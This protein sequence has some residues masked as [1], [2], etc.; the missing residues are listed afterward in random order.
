MTRKAYRTGSYLP[1]LPDLSSRNHL[2]GP[3][4]EDL[5]ASRGHRRKG[6]MALLWHRMQTRKEQGKGGLGRGRGSERGTA[7]RPPHPRVFIMNKVNLNS[8]P[9][10][11][12]WAWK[13]PCCVSPALQSVVGG[14]QDEKT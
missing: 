3:G 14:R 4:V 11:S 2:P 10:R 6:A 5:P 7:L 13:A 9:F 12:Q 8:V 1:L